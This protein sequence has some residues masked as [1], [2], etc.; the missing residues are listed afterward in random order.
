MAITTYR[1]LFKSF[2]DKI[3]QTSRSKLSVHLP[4]AG[5]GQ[6]SMSHS[7]HMSRQGYTKTRSS[8][9]SNSFEDTMELDRVQRQPSVTA[10]KRRGSREE[11]FPVKDGIIY[12]TTVE[13]THS[14]KGDDDRV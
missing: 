9:S 14:A 11:D 5:K 8:K 12:S 10:G 1:P 13:V 4:G 6:H 7:R 2:N 3:S